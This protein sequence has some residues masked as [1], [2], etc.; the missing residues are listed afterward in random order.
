MKKNLAHKRGDCC[1]RRCW[2]CW[3][4]GILAL[5]RAV[6]VSQHKRSLRIISMSRECLHLWLVAAARG[7]AVRHTVCIR[8]GVHNRVRV[9]GI[10]LSW[11]HLV[12]S[13]QEASVSAK[14]YSERRRQSHVLR[15]WERQVGERKDDVRIVKAHNR[16]RLWHAFRAMSKWVIAFRAASDACHLKQERVRALQ[17]CLTITA[18]KRRIGE[19]QTERA[20]SSRVC[21]QRQ[22]TS[23]RARLRFVLAEWTSQHEEACTVFS[24]V[25]ARADLTMTL[26]VLGAWWKTAWAEPSDCRRAKA[27]ASLSISFTCFCLWVKYHAMRGK[28]SAKAQLKHLHVL[29][30]SLGLAFE[31]WSHRTYTHASHLSFVERV[32]RL[33]HDVHSLHKHLSAWSS[34]SAVLMLARHHV[35]R[36]VTRQAAAMLRA[37]VCAWALVLC[38]HTKPRPN[39]KVAGL[40][41]AQ[42][43]Q[44]MM[45]RRKIMIWRDT[46]REAQNDKC[47]TAT[48]ARS[49][50]LNVVALWQPVVS[51]KSD[52]V[53]FV[54]ARRAMMQVALQRAVASLWRSACEDAEHGRLKVLLR[55]SLTLKVL[56]LQSV[57][58]RWLCQCFCSQRCR[59]LESRVLFGEMRRRF[60]SWRLQLGIQKVVA[61]ELSLWWEN[62]CVML[63]P[64]TYNKAA[65]NCVFSAWKN[66]EG[67]NAAHDSVW[68]RPPGLFNTISTWIRLFRQ[69]VCKQLQSNFSAA[70]IDWQS[71]AAI[72]YAQLLK[73]SA[74]I[75]LR[76][77]CLQICMLEHWRSR[78]RQQSALD[79]QRKKLLTRYLQRLYFVSRLALHSSR[80]EV[81]VCGQMF[82]RKAVHYF[83]FLAF[84]CWKSA[85]RALTISRA[86]VCRRLAS[87]RQVSLQ[88]SIAVWRRMQKQRKIQNRVISTQARCYKRRVL[89]AWT[90]TTWVSIRNS[91]VVH[92]QSAVG[93]GD[94]GG[95][96]APEGQHRGKDFLASGGSK[97]PEMIAP[98]W[99]A[100]EPV[101]RCTSTASPRQR[102][103][104]GWLNPFKAHP[105]QELVSA[106]VSRCKGLA[107]A[108]AVKEW[109][110]VTSDKALAR[111]FQ[112]RAILKAHQNHSVQ[113]VRQALADWHHIATRKS[114]I[115]FMSSTVSELVCSENKFYTAF[116][117]ALKH[118]NM[119]HPTHRDMYRPPDT[120]V[121][122]RPPIESKTVAASAP[123]PTRDDEERD[124]GGRGGLIPASSH[125][126][127]LDPQPIMMSSSPQQR[128]RNFSCTALSSSLPASCEVFAGADYSSPA[129]ST[130]SCLSAGLAE[131]VANHESPMPNLREDQRYAPIR[132]ALNSPAYALPQYAGG[133]GQMERERKQCYS[134]FTPASQNAPRA[135]A[136]SSATSLLPFQ[137][138]SS[139]RA[140]DGRRRATEDSLSATRWLPVG[141]DVMDG[142]CCDTPL[143][144][145]LTRHPSND[146]YASV[147]SGCGLS[148]GACALLVGAVSTPVRKDSERGVRSGYCSWR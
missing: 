19:Q 40:L 3:W 80:V 56:R 97:E 22:Q 35:E 5:R 85:T 36:M 72:A 7:A 8:V 89:R 87:Q 86:L 16:R 100:K 79:K 121:Y 103:M 4:F 107:M 11:E 42:H 120:D 147:Q 144:S 122:R 127:Q 10:F 84:S 132:S 47:F 67:Q 131:H 114:H 102:L 57:W 43:A 137:S 28:L 113:T 124:R 65:R 143:S 48:R 112:C 51:R 83:R 90:Q 99:V 53:Q 54:N 24:R 66:L 13:L 109:A 44:R 70:L 69:V 78:S 61:K 12:A 30:C 115:R 101:S 23:R 81:L 108:M 142:R 1:V 20:R 39:L 138:C 74:M 110:F 93:G 91:D 82:A 21:H 117:E 94:G 34:T 64:L 59:S 58:R 135:Q 134:D 41:A 123:G 46:V 31:S 106:L 29:R 68:H 105:T 73:V 116:S 104:G 76:N 37:S 139:L 95:L 145:N 49:R 119:H 111:R 33:R 118:H 38:L 63:V 128:A 98:S 6:T 133:G 25:S 60:E 96:T 88:E 32:G 75:G 9:G 15:G 17:S 141:G 26:K 71:E 45:K 55:C 126:L 27:A 146:V 148:P 136:R 2:Q 125:A 14:Q 62:A 130:R 52:I 18:W 50:V 129:P 140:P 77:Q 92:L